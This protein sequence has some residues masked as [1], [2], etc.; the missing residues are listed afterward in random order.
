[1]V[2]SRWQ[3]S[4]IMTREGARTN[5]ATPTPLVVLLNLLASVPS[6][7]VTTKAPKTALIRWLLGQPRHCLFSKRECLLRTYI[8][9]TSLHPWGTR[10]VAFDGKLSSH[11]QIRQTY[12]HCSASLLLSVCVL[13]LSQR[14]A[15]Y[16]NVVAR[17]TPM[18]A[19]G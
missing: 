16:C 5:L 19:D 7:H 2:A 6:A 4:Q 9:Y 8:L 12:R 17:S 13:W 10:Y 14:V 3:S 15:S 1:M 18:A 11:A